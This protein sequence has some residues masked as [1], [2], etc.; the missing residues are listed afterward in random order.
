MKPGDV[1]SYLELCGRE[2]TSLQRGMNFQLGDD[3]SVV[4][5]SVRPRAPYHDQVVDDGQTLIPGPWQDM[6]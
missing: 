5:R 4:L 3:H 2:G 6:Q 1:V